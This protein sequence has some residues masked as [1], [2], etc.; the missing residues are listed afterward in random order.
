MM[1]WICS[2]SGRT[3]S[4][5]SNMRLRQLRQ[6]LPRGL[7]SL[8]DVSDCCAALNVVTINDGFELKLFMNVR[9]E[10]RTELAELFQGQVLQLTFLFHAPLHGVSN[11]LVR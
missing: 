1:A 8:F 5:V 11:N 9:S 10:S 6:L 4:R 2:T 3:A 7:E